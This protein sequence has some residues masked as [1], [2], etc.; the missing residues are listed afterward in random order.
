M[1]CVTMFTTYIAV[2]FQNATVGVGA[3]QVRG[4]QLVHGQVAL[5]S[6]LLAF[7]V[8]KVLPKS[9]TSSSPPLLSNIVQNMMS[10]LKI[11]SFV[12]LVLQGI[13]GG[14]PWNAMAFMSLYW[15]TCG[16][17]DIE[18][19][20]LALLAGTGGV[21]GEFISGYLGD[22]AARRFPNRGRVFVAFTSVC[23]G[24]PF[25]LGMFYLVP[26][27]GH[28]LLLAAALQFSFHFVACWTVAAANKPICAELVRSPSQRA[29]IIALWCMLEG[30]SASIFGAPVVGFVSERFGYRL[31]PTTKIA[32]PEASA[33]LANALV[34]VGVISWVC[35]ATVWIAMAFTFPRDRQK[36]R[37]EQ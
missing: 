24:I 3:F 10:I 2:S 32:G 5:V 36:A 31:D 4:W 6:F 26:R 30:V 21:I 9:P 29:Q 19:G 20:R 34:G 7:F 35:C 22:A 11:P 33:A 15:S 16:F 23:L 1:A 27:D 37:L 14:V 25:Y 8:F 18:V 12:I 28:W 13:T 17:T